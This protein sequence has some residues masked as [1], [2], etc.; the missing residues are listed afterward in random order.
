VTL[1]AVLNV[2]FKGISDYYTK[3]DKVE[4]KKPKASTQS[5]QI[6]MPSI[7]TTTFSMT[8]D[9]EEKKSTE[10]DDR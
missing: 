3:E 9:Q 5:H 10:E 2:E 1:H 7:L 8:L 6:Q 4:F